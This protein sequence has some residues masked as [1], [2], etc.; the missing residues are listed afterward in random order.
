VGIDVLN[1]QLIKCPGVGSRQKLVK[2][3]KGLVVYFGAILGANGFEAY[4]FG[5]PV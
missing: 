1:F 5:K 2:P 3:L 4:G